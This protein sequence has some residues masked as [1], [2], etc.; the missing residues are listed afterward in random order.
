MAASLPQSAGMAALMPSYAQRSSPA[1]PCARYAVNG[2]LSTRIILCRLW[3]AAVRF[4]RTCKGFVMNA[5]AERPSNAMEDSDGPRVREVARIL[6][7]DDGHESF[8]IAV[9]RGPDGKWRIC[10]ERF[11]APRWTEAHEQIA[12]EAMAMQDLR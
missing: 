4:L 5:I 3:R 10:R 2:H 11:A 12:L 1:I 8:Q 6:V 9:S 7:I